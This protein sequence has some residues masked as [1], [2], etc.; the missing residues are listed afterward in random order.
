MA[1]VAL[2]FGVV[3]L[4][5]FVAFLRFFGFFLFDATGFAE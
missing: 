1:V 4:I 2:G 3:G 5:F